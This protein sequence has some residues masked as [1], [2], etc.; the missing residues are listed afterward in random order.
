MILW[1]AV[2]SVVLT[3]A[4][5]Q[6]PAIDYRLV[7][8]GAVLPVVES[9]WGAGFLHSLLAPTLVLLIVMLATTGRRLVRRRWLGL[10]IGMYLHLVLDGAWTRTETFWWPVLDRSFS[11]G[12]APEWSRGWWSLLLDVLAV[13]VAV[14]AYRR[15]GLDDPERRSR[16]L[17]T[18][19]LD[20]AFVAGGPG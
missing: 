18:G 6:S 2:L 20:R 12:A 9:P 13:A 3:W 4:V 7:A 11:P 8:L 17:R 14:W 15:F 5:F 16:F 10:P 1:F 19:Q